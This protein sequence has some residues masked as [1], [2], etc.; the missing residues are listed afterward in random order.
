MDQITLG[1]TWGKRGPEGRLYWRHQT[2]DIWKWPEM[3]A[4]YSIDARGPICSLWEPG[5]AAE[6]VQS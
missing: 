1:G 3:A 6:V 4:V 5:P 2:G